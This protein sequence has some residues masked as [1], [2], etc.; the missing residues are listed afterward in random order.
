MNTR[1]LPDTLD[2]TPAVGDMPFTPKQRALLALASELGRTKFAPRAA[3]WD[4]S[5]SFP[6]PTTTTC[7]TPAL[8]RCACPN[9][10]AGWAPT[11]PP[12]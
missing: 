7:A 8:L 3:Q 5:A 4:A 1:T 11:T 10:M 2:F 12:T 9:R 6:P